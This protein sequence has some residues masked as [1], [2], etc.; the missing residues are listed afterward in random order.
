MFSKNLKLRINTPRTTPS[1]LKI[2]Y[3][4]GHDNHNEHND[5][6]REF[7]KSKMIHNLGVIN[8]PEE[9]EETLNKYVRFVAALMNCELPKEIDPRN[10]SDSEIR[11][12]LRLLPNS[13]K[14]LRALANENTEYA[15]ISMCVELFSRHVTIGKS[16]LFA[17]LESV[18]KVM[19]MHENIGDLAT[20]K[21][22]DLKRQEEVSHFLRLFNYCITILE[23]ISVR[24][25]H[26]IDQTPNAVEGLMLQIAVEYEQKFMQIDH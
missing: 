17:L 14:I 16:P 21:L 8:S 15:V 3:L 19:E 11:T 20:M 26:Q 4:D 18:L 10:K 1:E 22:K 2:C 5:K 12:M 23:C 13:S 25:Y 7:V 9:Q 24:S 6:M